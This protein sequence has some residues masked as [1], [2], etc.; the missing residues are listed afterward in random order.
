MGQ[1]SRRDDLSWSRVV[2]Q[3][4]GERRLGKGVMMR[5]ASATW[6]S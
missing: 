3:C 4:F 5:K 1:P 2:E 6:G